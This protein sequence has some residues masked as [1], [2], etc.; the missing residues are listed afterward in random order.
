MVAQPRLQEALSGAAKKIL[1]G[2]LRLD[3]LSV[4]PSQETHFGSLGGN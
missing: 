1:A 2:E 4:Q 3:F